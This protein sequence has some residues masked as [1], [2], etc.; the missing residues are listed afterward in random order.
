MGPYDTVLPADAV[1]FCPHPAAT[2]IFAVGTYKLDDPP[3][4]SDSSTGV[5]TPSILTPASEEPPAISSGTTQTRH[6]KCLFFRV[7]GEADGAF[8]PLSDFSLPAVLDMKWLH[9]TEDRQPV[10]AIADSECNITLAE[11]NI[12]VSQVEARTSVVC[13]SSNVLCLSIDWNNRR[14]PTSSMASLIVSLS[15]GKLALLRP[16]PVNGLS[17]EEAWHAHDYEPWAAAWECWDHNL[18]YSGGD[19]L[20]LKLWDIRAGCDQPVQINRR[21][22]AGI[23]SIQSHPHIE[24]VI[25]VGSYDNTVRLYDRRKLTTPMTQAEVGGGAWRVKWNPSPKRTHDLLVAAMHD[26][27][28]VVK[29]HDMWTKEDTPPVFSEK[30]DVIERFD[31]HE[32]LAY[33]VDWSYATGVDERGQ[34]LIAS[35]SFYDCVLHTWRG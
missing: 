3:A 15:N 34:G 20:K 7:N 16:D 9:T 8:E 1:E 31:K 10:L 4:K 19:D 12:E 11:W 23:T 24:H 32:S 18:V 21:F 2:D 28:K 27:F 17:V 30:W 14:D 5:G 25:A 35:A 22:D 33:G 26:G 6:G 13:G 29:F